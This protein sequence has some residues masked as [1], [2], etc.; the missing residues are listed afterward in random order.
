[1]NFEHKIDLKED[2]PVY[3]KPVPMSEVHRDILKGQIKEWLKMGIIQPSRS[4]YNSPLFMVPKTD[5]SLKCMQYFGQLNARSLMI[6]IPRRTS[7][8]LLETLD[9]QGSQSLPL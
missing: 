6:Y 7:I 4:I 3:F 2:S 5:V 1:M 9:M 8:N